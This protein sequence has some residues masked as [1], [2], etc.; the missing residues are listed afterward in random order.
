MLGNNIRSQRGGIPRA[1][2]VAACACVFASPAIAQYDGPVLRNDENQE[3][4]TLNLPYEP[5]RWDVLDTA[6]DPRRPEL[7]ST[8][9]IAEIIAREFGNFMDGEAWEKAEEAARTLVAIAED[10]PAAHYNL[11]CALSRREMVEAALDSLARAIELGWR[12][13]AHRAHMANDPDLD[14]LRTHPRYAVL[15]TRL[16]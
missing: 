10:R 16:D 6:I 2:A 3:S 1:A 7:G 14:A 12:R 9:Q 15:I 4:G 5:P 8:N 13:A 11:A